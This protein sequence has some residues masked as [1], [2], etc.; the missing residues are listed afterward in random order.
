MPLMTRSQATC[1]Q[2][3]RFAEMEE[4]VKKMASKMENLLRENEILKQR[5]TGSGKGAGTSQNEQIEAEL[6]SAGE[7]M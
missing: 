5:N 7:A 2:E 4:R 6:Y 3:G 1:E